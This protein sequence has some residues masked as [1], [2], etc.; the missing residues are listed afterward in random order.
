MRR[1]PRPYLPVRTPRDRC[2]SPPV[3]RAVSCP[4]RSRPLARAMLSLSHLEAL[5]PFLNCP[6]AGIAPRRCALALA[7][8]C[9]L[10]G[11][12]GGAPAAPS[13]AARGAPPAGAPG[14]GAPA[15]T[16][17][18]APERV[19]ISTAGKSMTTMPIQ[20]ANLNGFFVGE[21]VEVEMVYADNTIGVAAVQAGDVE[22]M[23][24]ADTA[25]LGYFQGLPMRA[26]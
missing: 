6:A 21:G 24:Q 10:A 23:T 11:G 7:L 2:W 5:A 26:V 8:L 9:L 3:A 19:K 22:F 4:R 12:C 17:P 13:D 25:V 16:G 1:L 14:S 20:I 15:A 18:A